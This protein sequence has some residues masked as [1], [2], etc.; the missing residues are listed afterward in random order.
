[1]ICWLCVGSFY[2]QKAKREMSACSGSDVLVLE[3][4]SPEFWS[5]RVLDTHFSLLQ[6]LRSCVALGF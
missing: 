5:P 3:C 6:F 4:W 2:D 1:M